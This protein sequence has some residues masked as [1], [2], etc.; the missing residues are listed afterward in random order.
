MMFF[1]KKSEEILKK[2]DERFQ[3]LERG[4]AV[5][6]EQLEGIG[7][8][9]SKLQAAVHKHDMAIE[10][11]LE[12]WEEK[13]S[14]ESEVKEQFQIFKKERGYFLDLFASYQE[15][16]W[17]LKRFAEGKDE[18]WAA[19]IAL[20][21]KNLERY[22]QLCGITV[23]GDYGARV[24]YDM[25]EVIETVETKDPALDKTVADIYSCGYIYKGNVK[26]KARV[27]AYLTEKRN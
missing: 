1:K 25:H 5:Q 24:D 27:A 22:R 20:M 13:Q 17:N 18:T 15:Q 10:D 16:F 6:R 23:I 12:E 19:Q 21:E 9:I 7:Q 2:L 14:D 26:K 3:R 11:L 4:I 8:N